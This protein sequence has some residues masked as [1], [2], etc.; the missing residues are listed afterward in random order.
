[1]T[2]G[3]PSARCFAN[4]PWRAFTWTCALLQE[5]RTQPWGNLHEAVQESLELAE[6]VDLHQLPGLHDR[7]HTEWQQTVDQDYALIYKHAVQRLEQI[8]ADKQHY[9]HTQQSSQASRQADQATQKRLGAA[10]QEAMDS[11]P[12][13]MGAA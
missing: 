8:Y 4:A 11:K 6:A 12:A 10:V 5:T 3:N 2:V 7:R 9:I 1:M 13:Q